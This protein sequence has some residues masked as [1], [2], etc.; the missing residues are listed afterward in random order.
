MDPLSEHP[1]RLIVPA[2][3]VLMVAACGG[4]STTPTGVKPPPTQAATFDTLLSGGS[5]PSGGGSVTVHKS[6]DP[7]DGLTLTLSANAYPAAVSITIGSSNNKNL[8]TA[9]GIVPIS[10]VVHI[11]ASTGDYANGVI[12]L[13]VPA[14]VPANRFPVIVM[15]D[16][17][18]KA[19]EPLTTI[20]SDG[21]SVTAITAHMSNANLLR[22]ARMADATAGRTTA[23]VFGVYAIADSIL[24]RDWDTGFKPGTNDREIP[25]NSTE[26]ASSSNIGGVPTTEV[27]YFNTRAS[28]TPLFGRFPIVKN[29]ALSDKLGFDWTSVVSKQ[30]DLHITERADAA[31]RSVTSSGASQDT[32]QFDQVR[33]SFALASLQGAAPLPVLVILHNA[34]GDLVMAAYKAMGSKIWIADPAR[35]GDATQ[36][37]ELGAD[38]GMKPWQDTLITP[39][40]FTRPIAVSL[41]TLVPVALLASSYADVVANT[42][43]NGLFPASG[44]YSW[45]GALYDTMY[46]VDPLR[47]W[48]QCAQCQYGFATTLSPAPSGNVEKGINIYKLRN[49][50]AFDSLGFLGTNG[51]LVT[52]VPGNQLTLGIPLASASQANQPTTGYGL[53]WLDWHQF[54]IVQL[55]PTIA[56]VAPQVAPKTPLAL[57]LSVSPNVLPSDIAY[58]WDFG[59]KTS[60]LTMQN[61]AN[62]QHT[63]SDTGTYNVTAKIVDNRNAQV[64]ARG[65]TPVTVGTKPEV[66]LIQ[67]LTYLYTLKNG[68][69]STNDS[70]S[71]HGYILFLDSGSVHALVAVDGPPLPSSTN[72]PAGVGFYLAQ[73]TDSVSHWPNVQ[74]VPL[75]LANAF[76]PLDVVAYADSGNMTQGSI[77]GKAQSTTLA[78]GSP[79][80]PYGYSVSLTKKG[81][82]LSGYIQIQGTGMNG[83][84]TITEVTVDSVVAQRVP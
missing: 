10:P 28:S 65:T 19:M 77:T 26:A 48:A 20:A 79:S 36:F 16:S 54:T 34:G 42:I 43:G 70:T 31:Y 71:N 6:G 59:D 73:P 5:I 12:Q 44:F 47:F 14:T 9:S 33:A 52:S 74:G 75:A 45:G 84:Q 37:I 55:Q 13:T 82:T 68:V 67:S 41:G 4:S 2:L 76:S 56:P 58:Q 38:S 46:V 25:A 50:L 23:M 39:R 57:A 53:R 60:V 80:V 83:G 22:T 64:I 27:W 30:I 61:N 11:Q 1:V 62:V 51:L 24:Y 49:G 32:L 35:P 3:V 7:L 21:K 17:A 29:V 63:Y 18:T 78:G 72:Y 40:Y 81:N 66:W 15:Y 69:K 8:P